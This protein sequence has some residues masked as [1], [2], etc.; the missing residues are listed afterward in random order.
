[1]AF[2]VW[3]KDSKDKSFAWIRRFPTELNRNKFKLGKGI[4]CSDWFPDHPEIQVREDKGIV[5]ADSI[6][7]SGELLIVSEKLKTVLDEVE[8]ADFEFF[9]V[10]ILDKKGRASE[11]EYYV[12]NLLSVIDCVNMV[13]SKYVMDP[14]RK[15]QVDWFSELRLDESRIPADQ[16][17]FRLKDL[18]RLLIVRSELVNNIQQAD[19]T[20]IYFEPV[21]DH[22]ALFR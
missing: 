15:G 21:E 11:K 4:S 13:E 3:T 6:P 19:C 14:L 22:G 1:M 10:T 16:L 12:A 17:V 5:L 2:Y 18:T 7:N 8:G 9:P 20:G